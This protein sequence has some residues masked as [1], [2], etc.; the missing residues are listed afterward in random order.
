LSER[1][2]DRLLAGFAAWTVLANAAV[3][4]GADLR[5]LV[6]AAALL[7]LVSGGVALARRGRSRVAEAPVA[8]A[9]PPAPATPALPLRAAVLV[10]AGALAGAWLLAGALS[11]YSAGVVL[12][13]GALVARELRVP[14]RGEPAPASRGERAALLGLALLCAAYALTAHRPDADDAFYLGLA[15]AAA[16]HPTAP[17]LASDPIHGIA[18]VPL[19]L[20]IY[21]VH[22]LELLEAA[23]AWLTPLRVLDVA[24][25]LL[26]ALAAFLVPL[27]HAR[28]LRLLAP[29]RWLWAVAAVV[30]WLVLVGAPHQGYGNFG[31]V[32]LHQ[33]KA[34]LLCV[35]LP[36]VAALALEYALAPSRRR[37]LRLAAVQV[38][39]LGTSATGLWAAPVVAGLCLATAAEWRATR[40]G[41]LAL[42][43]AASAYPLGL[44]LALRGSTVAA[45][46]AAPPTQWEANADA[47]SA[48]A[49][50]LGDGGVAALSLFVVAG[51][52]ALATSGLQRRFAAVF[53]CAFALL[54]WNPW[55][56]PWIAHTVTG[57]PTYW[58]VFWLL[59]VPLLVA[60]ALTAPLE[61][62]PHR[63]AG[64]A[65]AL[66]AAI[67]LFVAL[68]A[69]PTWSARNFVH[70]GPPQWKI[71]PAEKAAA[72]ALIALA[73][74]G[75]TV[76][77]ATSVSRWLPAF[78]DAPV[79]LVARH[80]D[81]TILRGHLSDAEI[82]RRDE[83]AS[84]VS[85]QRRPPEA[86]ALLASAIE[87]YPLAAVCLD[88]RALDWPELR[89]ALERSP[90][91]LA[92]RVGHYE[93]W[94]RP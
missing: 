53:A 71:P 41:R 3:F 59:P 16:T 65:V 30:A 21:K 89:A 93:I 78:E 32:R 9:T 13:C 6:L 34:I 88:G 85:G 33:G 14:P 2:A 20:P 11:L 39:A 37:W 40:L 64:A 48:L 51:G 72:R 69:V 17:L 66:A 81:L 23:L 18:G 38:V 76:L 28:L 35:V 10:A 73:P 26:P 24:H 90:L 84:L 60:L 94:A 49:R 63:A 43:L 36:A 5:E 57:V 47:A 68:P 45:F 74:P 67:V 62:V 61:L 27:V 91:A 44:A 70:V 82:A 87:G 25:L 8:A 75:A 56:A 12:L 79:P 4:L 1:A 7:A 31:F 54:F 29:R 46:A 77:A 80:L 15:V 50:V 52:W 42:G 58:R 55:V 19:A 92:T 86:G 83:L 22:S